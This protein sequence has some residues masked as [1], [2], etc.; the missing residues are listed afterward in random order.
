MWLIAAY[1]AFK[2]MIENYLIRTKDFFRRIYDSLTSS[3][4]ML[5]S[6]I[7]HYIHYFPDNNLETSIHFEDMVL[8]ER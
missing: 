6:S 3:D 7:E 8:M 4:E 1:Q 2:K 5:N